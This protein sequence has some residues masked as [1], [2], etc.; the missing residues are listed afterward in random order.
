MEVL[1]WKLMEEMKQGKEDAS[2]TNV[3]KNKMVAGSTNN[4]DPVAAQNARS[5]PSQDS[6]PVAPTQL[7][8]EAPQVQYEVLKHMKKILVISMFDYLCIFKPVKRLL[9]KVMIHIAHQLR[10]QEAF[11]TDSPCQFDYVTDLNLLECGKLPAL[12][13][14]D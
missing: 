14:I 7:S 1:V 12:L 8:T 2:A 6:L 13:P 10:G 11:F 3:R 4:L 9:E 5:P